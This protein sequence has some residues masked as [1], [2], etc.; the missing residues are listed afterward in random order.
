MLTLVKRCILY[1]TFFGI[2]YFTTVYFP[3]SGI[4]F[5]GSSAEEFNRNRMK[6]S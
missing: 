2:I 1:W 3:S 5:A 6:V 4:L